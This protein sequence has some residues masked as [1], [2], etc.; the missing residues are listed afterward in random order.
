MFDARVRANGLTLA[1]ARTLFHLAA[2]DGMT[3]REL[4][5]AL[6]IEGPTLVRLLDGLERQGAIAR[7]PVDGDRRA[8]QISLTEAGRTL[9]AEVQRL[10]DDLRQEV[11]SD[12]AEAD[13]AATTELLRR[14]ARKVEEMTAPG[15]VD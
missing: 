8:N 5:E 6:E 9:A 4:A 11:L 13:L 14:I 10:A 1:R 15:E 7:R 12:I 3:Q 2:R